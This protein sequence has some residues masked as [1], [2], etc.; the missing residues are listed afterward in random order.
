MKTL[1]TTFALLAAPPVS[2]GALAQSDGIL[3]NSSTGTLNFNVNI[4]DANRIRIFGF[5]DMVQTVETGVVAEPQRNQLNSGT[6]VRARPC[7]T[8]DLPDTKVSLDWAFTPMTDV[9]DDTKIIPVELRIEK[10]TTGLVGNGTP[11]VLLN[12]SETVTPQSGTVPDV[13]AKTGGHGTKCTSF[14]QEGVL[15]LQYD[16][17][18]TRQRTFQT[19]GTFV[20]TVTFTVKP[21]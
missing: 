15:D 1:L 2:P 3:G 8:A 20:S 19:A 6:G 13:E 7:I 21:Q 17:G 18:S 10:N 11:I 16:L 12:Q 14:D 9:S 4:S 5:T